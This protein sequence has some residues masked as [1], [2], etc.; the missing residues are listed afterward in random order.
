MFKS[1][2]DPQVQNF[3]HE[4]ENDDTTELL[5]KRKEMLGIPMLE[6]VQ[7]IN[8][9][10]KARHKLPSLFNSASI[11]Y[12]RS[13]N[14][15]QSSSEKTARNKIDILKN[16]TLAR[17]IA[18][19]LTGGFGVDSFFLS[20]LFQRVQYLEPDKQLFEIVRHNHAQLG[21]S[22]I[23]HFNTT[24]ESF[25]DNSTESF[26]FVF[27]D[28]SRRVE[29]TKVVSLRESEPD[30]ISL[31]GK[32]FQHTSLLLMKASPMLDISVGMKE[33]ENVKT[34]FV[35]AV[36]NEVKE[37]LFLCEK[38]FVGNPEIVAQNLTDSS[39]DVFTFTLAEEAE[40]TLQYINPE[41][42]LYEPNAAIMKAG[43]FKLLAA[44]FP[45]HKIA[46]STHL[47]TS[48]DF[49]PDF[50]GRVFKIE[51]HVKPDKSING[52]FPDGKANVT[53]RNYPLSVE[54]I[55]NR[56]KLKDGGD[57]FLIG[58]SGEKQ[59]FLVVASRIK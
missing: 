20:K 12:P 35:V 6:I 13:V 23:E 28:P 52:F 14:L 7:Q 46:T 55:K 32:I 51:R 27:V 58:F 36:D 2:L 43:A 24:A 42:Y 38:N 26:D 45:I 40:Q 25:L 41:N 19:D 18:A 1:L 59:K 49:V 8:G 29:K 3:I 5:L 9:R 10:K 39:T 37:L 54:E 56:T 34:V 50:P 48:I 21:V 16:E 33:L 31:K 15:E 53:T 30:I 17:R 11:I 22:N 57:K 47:Y 44:K 4:H